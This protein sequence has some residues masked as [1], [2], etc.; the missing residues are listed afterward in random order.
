MADIG[1]ERIA[2]SGV[3]RARKRSC[4]AGIPA[5]GTIGQRSRS[6]SGECRR[7]TRRRCRT[8]AEMPVSKQETCFAIRGRRIDDLNRRPP[9]RA[10]ETDV[11]HR[12]PRGISGLSGR[13]AGRQLVCT[14]RVGRCAGM[15]QRGGGRP[16]AEVVGKVAQHFKRRMHRRHDHEGDPANHKHWFDSMHEDIQ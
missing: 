12:D 10:G 6:G 8:R 2:P 5:L 9:H 3:G 15:V 13:T 1:P 16:A 14:V 11:G 7:G 4:T